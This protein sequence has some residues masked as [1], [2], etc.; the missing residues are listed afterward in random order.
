MDR[1]LRAL[2]LTPLV[3]QQLRPF[4]ATARAEDLEHLRD[5]LDGGR[6]TPVIDRTFPL[7]D[8][9]DAIRYLADGRVRG[10][11]VITI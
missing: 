6:L 3:S 5:L 8:A 4:I 7:R 11:V 2:M 9:P 10:K 1:Q